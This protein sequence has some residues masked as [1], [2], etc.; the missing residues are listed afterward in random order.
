MGLRLR[1]TEP[2]HLRLRGPHLRALPESLR[3]TWPASPGVVAWG[4][5]EGQAV[6]PPARVME[7]P[8]ALPTL[9][10]HPSPLLL[11]PFSPPN[12]HPN[13]SLRFSSCFFGAKF[14]R[15]QGFGLWLDQGGGG[16]IGQPVQSP[17]GPRNPSSPA[18]STLSQGLWGPG[19][20]AIWTAQ[21]E[22][23]GE[24]WR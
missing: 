10:G 9:A 23:Q 5:D 3:G 24:G 2:P 19:A 11:S 4:E 17:Q 7:R 22:R 8:D 16:E 6:M 12:P 20:E 18:S 1:H 13:S 21:L 15:S 14:A